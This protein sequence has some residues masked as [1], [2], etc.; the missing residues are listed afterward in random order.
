MNPQELTTP[1]RAYWDIGPSSSLAADAYRRI[2]GEIAANKLLSLQITETAARIGEACLTVLDALRPAPVALSLVAPLA[3]LD[4]RS[5][6][7]LRQT[8]VK[9]VFASIASS[10][11]VAAVAERAARTGARPAVGISFPVSRRNFRDLPLLLGSCIDRRIAHLLLPMQR[12]MTGEA[13]FVF[14]RAERRELTAELGA[15][16]RPA[17]LKITIH[18]PFLWRAFYPDVEFPN[19]GCQAANTM[20]YISPD[21]LVYPCPTVPIVIGDLRKETLRDIILS[22]GKKKVRKDLLA[23]AADCADCSESAVCRGG[24]RGRAYAA[25]GTLEANDPACR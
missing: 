2:A 5:L 16:K 12:L 1:I 4:D 25:G 24:C 15:V 11:D 18:D 13:C 6:D 10:G 3:A 22:D 23:A 7:A 9:V 19:G 21:A 8:T 20:L 17:S 14:S